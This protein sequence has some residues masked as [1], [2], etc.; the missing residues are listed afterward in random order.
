MKSLLF[1]LLC[2]SVLASRKKSAVLLV[3]SSVLHSSP[4]ISAYGWSV[5]L[6]FHSTWAPKSLGC[7]ACCIDNAKI[8]KWLYGGA[9]DHGGPWETIW[10]LN[11]FLTVSCF[12]EVLRVLNASVDPSAAVHHCYPYPSIPFFRRVELFVR[13]DQTKWA[14][15]LGGEVGFLLQYI[16]GVFGFDRPQ[17]RAT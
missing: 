1:Q 5:K 15:G 8:V 13:S 16:T 9:T 17:D 7:R 6:R 12:W 4:Q 3:N 10:S 2:R 14:L 11:G